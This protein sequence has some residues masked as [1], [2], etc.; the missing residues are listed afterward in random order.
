MSEFIDALNSAGAAFVGFAGRMLVQSSLLILGLIVL[1]LALRRRVKAVVRYWV[2]LLVLV[3]LILPPSL[4]SPTS[5]AYWIGD[6]LP[7]LPQQTQPVSQTPMTSPSPAGHSAEPSMVPTVHTR[8]LPASTAT[9]LPRS[10]IANAEP[11]PAAMVRGD[12]PVAAVTT[13]PAPPVTWQAVLMLAWSVVV[14]VMVVLLIQRALFVHGLVAQ[15]IA[16]PD[17]LLQLLGACRRQLTV[18]RPVGLRLSALSMSPSVCGLRRP[19]ILM[20]Q[21]MLAELDTAQLKSVLLHELAHIKRGDLWVNLAQALLQIVYF[22]HPLFWLA[23][24]IIRRVREQAVDETVLAA[25]GEEAEEYP[26]TLLSVSRLAFGRPSLSL[27]LLGVVESKTA[28]TARIK[29]IVG[30]PFPRNAKLGFAGLILILTVGAFLLPMAGARPQEKKAGPAA[31]VTPDSMSL[32]TAPVD[33]SADAT[34][35]I[36]GVVTD[37]LGRPRECVHMAPQGQDPW[38]GPMSDIEGRFTLEKV[39]PD[40]K[41]WIAYS[42]ASRLYGFFTLPQTVPAGPVK[43]VLNLGEAD[44]EGRVVGAD[45]KPLVDRTVEIIVTTPDGVRF[46]L[47]HQPK[48]DVYGYYSHGNVPCGEGLVMEATL[49][50]SGDGGASFSTVP[51]QVRADQSFIELPVLVAARQKI[52]P[53]F[54][55]NMKEDGALH[56]GGRVLDEAGNPIAGVRVCLSFDI[57]GYMSTWSRE[58][59]TDEQGRWHRPAPPECMG[60]SVEF[61]HP[62]YYLDEPRINAPREELAGGSHSIV[63][64]RGLLLEGR[65]VNERGEPVENAL[66]CGS[67]PGSATP[68]PYNQI[69]E[70]S[71]MT[72]TLHDGAF[73]IRGLSPG[74]RDILVYPD[75]HAP[76]VQ[77]VDIREGMAPVR[78]VVKAGRTYRGRIVDARGDPMEGILVGTDRWQTGKDHRWMSRLG[79]TDAR[80]MFALANLPEGQIQIDFGRKKGYLGF[81][82]DLPADLSQ[83]DRVVM[84]EV[85]TFTGRVVD[86]D[87]NE[88][89]AEFEIVNGIRRDDDQSLDWSRYHSESVK[90]A[91][92]AFTHPWAGY[93]VSYPTNAAACIKIETRG[94]VPSAPVLLE[95]GQ[96]CKPVTIRMKK[97]APVTGIALQSDG[98]PAAKAQV[99]LVRKGEKA[100]IDRDQFSADSFAQQAEITATAD[101]EGRFELPPTGE[102]GLLVVVHRSGYAQVQSSQ[103][104]SGSSIR[105]QA[106]ARVEG[107]I[108]RSGI[109]EKEIEIA[110]FTLGEDNDRQTPG[111]YWLIGSMTPTGDTFAFD[112]VPSVPLAVGRISRYE[113]HDGSC[114]VPEPGKTYRVPID[115]KGHAV[116]GRIVWPGEFP[117]GRSV[118]FTDPRCVH[119]VAFGTD[120]SAAIVGDVAIDEL[121]FRWLWQGKEDVYKPSTTVRKRFI[122]TIGEDGSFTLRGLE[123]GSYEFVVN[124]HAPLGENVSCGRGVLEAVAVSRFTV[125]DDQRSEMIRVSDIHLHAL[126]YPKAGEPAPLFEA[127]TFDGATVRLADLRGKVVL[128]D[129]WATWCAPC[130]AQLPQVQQMHE[131]FGDNDKFAMVGMSLDWDIERARSF[132]AR[133]PLKW[134]QVSLGSMD[135]SV[136]VRQYGVGSIPT[137][138]LI[139][140]E[141]RIIAAGLSLD[142]LKEPIRAALA[143]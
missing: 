100:F 83:I 25:M 31:T 65:V 58:A 82:K 10:A 51:A 74:A 101:V 105:L 46:P 57:P 141:G 125:P 112:C 137:A 27:R 39:T 78:V 131:T 49:V 50:D 43:A 77:A 117:S 134:P 64:K 66:V 136:V 38:R 35:T 118:P 68:S 61:K 119:A 111:I 53:D 76:V 8:H 59:L 135:T 93:G 6:R 108:D 30:R 36:E 3:K 127:R 17:G 34:R 138:V 95:L 26:R 12:S 110:L 132:L 133:R 85:P 92:G 44:L 47:D 123:P 19:A 32:Q 14:L 143:K 87:T 79:R 89:V 1:D 69:I 33:S 124:V 80:G 115:A 120:D 86:A 60:L 62:E 96:T 91:G 20:P 104:T 84:Y 140:P 75:H 71:G 22:F 139:D 73:C 129:F 42:Q 114:F 2:W 130:V 99:A 142:Q 18:N 70:D 7:S 48:T 56:C 11:V 16:A 29:L 72:R 13:P 41:V 15:S 37:T 126:A 55:R 90:N 88:P 52:Q 121:P 94:Y 5:L 109:D 23:N 54:D 102:Q 28:L 128:L 113:M 97:G 24:T 106:W 67:R 116:D 4:S 103:F 63:M 45:G 107:S 98:A 9:Q 122:P 81:R 21:A 40:Q